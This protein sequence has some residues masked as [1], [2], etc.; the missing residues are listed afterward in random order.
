MV[1]HNRSIRRNNGK[2]LKSRMRGG[3]SAAAAAAQPSFTQFD[4]VDRLMNFITQTV[5]FADFSTLEETKSWSTLVEGRRFKNVQAELAFRGHHFTEY[6]D[7]LFFNKLRGTD[8]DLLTVSRPEYHPFI[9]RTS[10]PSCITRCFTIDSFIHV[11]TSMSITI[12]ASNKVA[13]DRLFAIIDIDLSGHINYRK[14][15][16][17][18]MI[19][20]YYRCMTASL[21]INVGQATHRDVVQRYIVDN[22]PNWMMHGRMFNKQYFTEII[23][24]HITRMDKQNL[25]FDD[26]LLLMYNINVDVM[27]WLY[28]PSQCEISSRDKEIKDIIET[29][30]NHHSHTA[31]PA[32]SQSRQ[33][34]ASYRAPSA[35]GHAASQSRQTSASGRSRS[36]RA[37]GPAT[38]QYRQ[39][40]ASGHAASQSRQTSASGQ[41]A[42]QYRQP[43]AKYGNSG[44]R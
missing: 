29:H 33:S 2:R 1:R 27:G 19:A 17:F 6:I 7:D 14:F 43:S 34:S 8:V 5:I 38:S 20:H 23:T 30:R 41:V 25:H 39:P 21:T 18:S 22:Y 42:S 15:M 40:S 31:G 13:H 12:P 44:R 32:L 26:F 10:K 9:I 35:S 36:P 37:S 24:T 28:Q 16:L 3:S 4:R 11:L